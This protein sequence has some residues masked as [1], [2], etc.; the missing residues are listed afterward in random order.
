MYCTYIIVCTEGY[1]VG[2]QRVQQSMLELFYCDS[3]TL[4]STYN[5][6]SNHRLYIRLYYTIHNLLCGTYSYFSDALLL[7][8]DPPRLAPLPPPPPPHL[9]H[10]DLGPLEVSTF[11]V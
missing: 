3:L 9:L 10:N 7:G 4:Y 8:P 5:Y 11:Q 2:I 6:N 1:T